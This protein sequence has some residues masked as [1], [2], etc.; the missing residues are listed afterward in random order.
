MG[1]FKQLHIDCYEGDCIVNQEET[2]YMQ[3]DNPSYYSE[4]TNIKGTTCPVC[5]LTTKT[6]AGLSKH[7]NS[8]HLNGLATV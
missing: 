8:K 7:L 1:Y 3:P 2:C 6:L 5:K 4:V